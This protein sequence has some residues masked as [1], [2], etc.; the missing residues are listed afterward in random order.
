MKIDSKTTPSEIRTKY[1]T[2]GGNTDFSKVM[3]ETGGAHGNTGTQASAPT[4]NLSGIFALQEISNDEFSRKRH[5]TRGHD[6]LDQLERLRTQILS[7]ALSRETLHRIH[8]LITERMD[9]ENDPS[10][11]A[12]LGEIELRAQVELAKIETSQQKGSH[13]V[14]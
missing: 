8:T 14:S 13:Y 12:L 10:L 4:G 3:G 6:I 11:H 9:Q 1:K 2:P 7:G 5:I